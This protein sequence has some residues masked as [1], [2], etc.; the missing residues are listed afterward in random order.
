MKKALTATVAALAAAL[1]CAA[2]AD[3]SP[4]LT[5]DEYEYIQSLREVGID[6]TDAGK[7]LATAEDICY[8]ARLGFDTPDIAA[9]LVNADNPLH[10]TYAQYAVAQARIHICPDTVFPASI[11]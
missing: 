4:G 3:A 9:A 5:D 6:A 1:F 2:T 8:L 7:A 10:A 11:T